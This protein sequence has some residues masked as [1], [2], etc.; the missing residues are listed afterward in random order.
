MTS[1]A[2]TAYLTNNYVVFC[3]VAHKS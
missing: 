2:N 1:M 3:V